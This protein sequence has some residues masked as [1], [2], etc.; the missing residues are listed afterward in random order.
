MVV[1]FVFV[2]SSVEIKDD[3]SHENDGRNLSI[4]HRILLPDIETVNVPIFSLK[5]A[6]WAMTKNFRTEKINCVENELVFI[7]TNKYSIRR[8]KNVIKV[9]IN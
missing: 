1:K 7:E 9:I 4:I 6:T 3:L 5:R 8:I 2:A